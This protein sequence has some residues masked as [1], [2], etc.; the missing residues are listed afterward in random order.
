MEMESE[1]NI[2]RWGNYLTLFCFLYVINPL[3][4]FVSKAY[5]FKHRSFIP[6]YKV[7]Y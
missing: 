1:K 3:T 7:D 6:V 5:I 2:T 4:P